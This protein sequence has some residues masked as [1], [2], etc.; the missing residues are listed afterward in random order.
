MAKR[1]IPAP[2]ENPTLVIHDLKSNTPNQFLS[3]QLPF[4]QLLVS[5]PNL[6]DIRQ[7]NF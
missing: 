7:S 3:I 2:T 4:K 5:I 1:K 6:I